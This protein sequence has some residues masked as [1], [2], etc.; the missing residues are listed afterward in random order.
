MPRELCSSAVR[1]FTGL[2]W[3]F[4]T[5][6]GVLFSEPVLALRTLRHM[7]KPRVGALVSSPSWAP[8]WQTASQYCRP[9]WWDSVDIQP[10]GPFRW[11]Q[12][13]WTNVWL[14]LDKR[15]R[16]RRG[17]ASWAQSIQA[18]REMMKRR[19]VVVVVW[20]T[21]MPMIKQHVCS[22]LVYVVSW[23]IV[24]FSER[25]LP[26]H[27]DSVF[28]WVAQVLYNEYMLFISLHIIS[29]VTEGGVRE[30]Q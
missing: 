19:G 8:S 12:L 29:K 3:G 26:R 25:W 20:S 2:T 9:Q 4:G 22:G 18:P 1:S 5:A 11:P 27:L 16:E 30:K 21:P 13:Q 24:V 6:R 7:M 15:P 10:R 28:E 17:Q 23:I 14:Q